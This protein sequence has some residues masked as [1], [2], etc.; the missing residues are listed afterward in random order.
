MRQAKAVLPD[1]NISAAR[2]WTGSRPSF[3]DGIPV[4]GPLGRRPGLYGGFGHSHH[5]LMMAPQTGEVLADLVSGRD[6]DVDLAPLRATRFSN[7]AEQE[8]G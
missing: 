3:P 4:L 7:M 1:L 2:Y 6:P 8:N 5:G